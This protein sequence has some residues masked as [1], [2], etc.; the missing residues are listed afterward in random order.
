M[1]HFAN[2]RTWIIEGLTPL[3]E[4]IY[5]WHCL[6]FPEE[7]FINGK[8]G[9]A[10]DSSTENREKA[11]SAIQVFERLVKKTTDT[12]KIWKSISEQN[13]GLTHDIDTHWSIK[14]FL[15]VLRCVDAIT[16]FDSM[17]AREKEPVENQ[18]QKAFETLKF[19]LESTGLDQV[20]ISHAENPLQTSETARDSLSRLSERICN[21]IEHS[22]K[23]KGGPNSNA[24]RFARHL[25]DFHVR[26][27]SDEMRR[28]IALVTNVLYDTSYTT[29]EITKNLHAP[30]D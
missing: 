1:V 30:A 19:R 13:Q 28:E 2:K 12:E 10:S 27:F 25:R 4:Y 16:P 20:V 22:A 9:V 21:R 8:S 14:Y 24:I 3:H 5:E 15:V 17:T 7:Y 18:I 6:S 11:L 23:T 26:L 29:N